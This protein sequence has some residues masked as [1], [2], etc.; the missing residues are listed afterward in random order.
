MEFNEI[1]NKQQKEIS[2][3]QAGLWKYQ[4]SE[5]YLAVDR[6]ERHTQTESHSI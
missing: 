5:K 6:W 1:G 4:W 2:E 3:T